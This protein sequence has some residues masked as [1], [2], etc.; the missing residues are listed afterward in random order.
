[1][2]SA[3]IV[4][5]AREI[6]H[7]VGVRGMTMRALAAEL[8]VTTGASYRHLPSRDA[9]LDEV[10]NQVMTELPLPEPEV[11]DWTV[12]LEQFALAVRTAFFA[13]PGLGPYSLTK[14]GWPEAGRRTANW[15]R[16]VLVEAGYDDDAA[17]KAQL[18]FAMI[19]TSALV[20]EPGSVR[21]PSE[22]R[23]GRPAVESDDYAHAL[24]IVLDGLRRELDAG[25][26]TKSGN[27]SAGTS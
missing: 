10:V 22:A 4:S 24:R 16:S 17:K 25:V 2:D 18:I 11:G 12:R 5:A 26:L 21:L 19:A 15:V 6:I 3:R 8:G 14:S 23:L 27:E 9:V 1:L 20:F 13:L 7:R